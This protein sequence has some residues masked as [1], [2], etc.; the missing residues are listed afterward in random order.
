M[1]FT[2][3][4]AAFER[5]FRPEGL[6]T[7]S[8]V[9]LK[10]GDN[11]AAI[12]LVARQGWTSR[13]AAMAIAPEYR[14]KGVGQ[15][16]MNKVIDDARARGDQRLLLEV[17]E[18]N[19]PAIALYESVGMT[20]TRRLVGYRREPSEGVASELERIDPSVVIRNQAVE[21]SED[22]PWDFK[23]ETLT[24]KL[25]FLKGFRL[26]DEAFALLSDPPGERVIIWT[27]FTRK[28]ARRS[29]LGRQ[30]IEAVAALYPTRAIVTSVA[31]PDDHELEFL[32][33]TGFTE[34]PI[35]QFE[36]AIDLNSPRHES[37]PAESLP[38]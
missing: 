1:T 37:Q 9:L 30:L 10:S 17:I 32:S 25:G 36:M 34:I 11:F 16:L 14:R 21:C 2:L 33:A 38:R 15:Y 24:L 19:P 31:L 27:L 12:C 26:N 13:V 28:G 20:K 3:D 5:R 6:D 29:G 35:S 7:V 23:P 8:S 22:L 18:Q 4:A